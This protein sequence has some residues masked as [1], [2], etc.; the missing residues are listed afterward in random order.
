MYGGQVRRCTS[1]CA[2][3]MLVGPAAFRRGGTRT[4]R[5]ASPGTSRQEMMS[6]SHD[7]VVY[8]AKPSIKLAPSMARVF[9][10]RFVETI[11]LHSLLIRNA[12]LIRNDNA[13]FKSKV[14]GKAKC[15]IIC[16]YCTKTRLCLP[17]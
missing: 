16:S 11:A 9:C 2:G 10:S 8:W 4:E 6:R 12:L 15:Q 5:R 1:R 17:K 3:G 14:G 7:C 13:S